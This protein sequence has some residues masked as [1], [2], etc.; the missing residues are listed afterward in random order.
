MFCRTVSLALFLACSEFF[1]QNQGFCSYKIVLIKKS[2]ILYIKTFLT[3]SHYTVIIVITKKI[4][5]RNFFCI[6]AGDEGV[7]KAC[8][9]KIASDVYRHAFRSGHT[10][11]FC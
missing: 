4:W 8:E 1:Y 10:E 6:G 7:E 3:L 2:V 5:A 11:V 9:S